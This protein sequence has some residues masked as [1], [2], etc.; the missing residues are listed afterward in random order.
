M[1]SAQYCC[2]CCFHVFFKSSTMSKRRPVQVRKVMSQLES[3]YFL[4]FFNLFWFL[5]DS[6]FKKKLFF[7]SSFFFLLWLLIEALG[8]NWK[9]KRSLC[10]FII[11]WKW[12]RAAMQLLLNTASPTFIPRGFTKAHSERRF[13]SV[14]QSLSGALQLASVVLVLFSL[15]SFILLSLH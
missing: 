14:Q 10:P 7:R 2:P 9:K 5:G 6:R 13:T 15:S 12:R 3:M 4:F 1:L 11:K 8:C